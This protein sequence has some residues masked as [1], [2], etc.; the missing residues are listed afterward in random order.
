M[1]SRN[2]CGFGAGS[3]RVLGRASIA[4]GLLVALSTFAAAQTV[5]QNT[6]GRNPGTQVPPG[7]YIPDE[8]T[9]AEQTRLHSRT[10]IGAAGISAPSFKFGEYNGLNKFHAFAIGNFDYRGG[11]SYDSTDAWQWRF[12]GSSLGLET[13][14]GILDFGK[15]GK[16]QVRFAY[17]ELLANTSDSYQTPFL[18]VGSDTLSLPSTWV[19]PILPQKNATALNYFALNPVTAAGSVYNSKGVLTAPTQAQ[20]NAM[21]AIRAADLPAFRNVDLSL[22]RK[23]GETQLLFNPTASIDIPVSYSREHKNGLRTIGGVNDQNTQDSALLPYR[24]NW[25]TDQTSAAVNVKLHKLFL[26][27]AYYGS[28]FHNNTEHMLW[29]DPAVIGLTSA[30]AEEPSSQ[31]HQFTATGSYKLSRDAKLVV[32]GSIGRGTQNQAFINPSLSNEG[33]LPFGLPRPSLQGL[34]YTGL[35]AGKFTLKHGKWEL[36]A[37]ARFDERDNQTPLGIFLFQ[38]DASPKT[39]KSPFSGLY[40]LP[41]GLGTN[42]NIY[43]NRSLSK[44]SYKAGGEAEYSFSKSEHL[45]LGYGWD[46]ADRHCSYSWITCA[47][48]KETNENTFRTEWRKSKGALTARVEYAFSE[49]RGDYNENAFLAE[50]PMANQ[51]P[52]G[53]ASQSAYSYLKSTGLTGFGP[54]AGLPSAPLTGDAAIFTPNN[55]TLAQAQYGTRNILNEIPGFKRYYVADRNR[56]DAR[57][58]LLWL[59]KDKVAIEGSGE[60]SDDDYLNT[61]LGLK[62]RTWWAATMDVSYTASEDLVADVFYTYDNQRLYATGDAFGSNST[63]KFQGQAGDTVLGGPCFS[64]VAARN[65][66]AKIDPCLNWTHNDRDKIDT[67]GLTLRRKNL[68][69]GKLEL[70]GEAVYTRGRTENAVVGGSYVNNPLA[71][72]APAPKLPA[73]TQAIFFIPAQNYPVIRNDEVMV[74]PSA[75]Y[76]IS[77]AASLQGFYWFQRLSP[78]DW[79]YQGL[80]A[81]NKLNFTPTNETVPNYDVHVGGLAFNWAF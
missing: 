21:A 5:P 32:V 41:T 26:S 29:A 70:A 64:T 62:R 61:K 38:D 50:T 76:V 8:P 42:T 72:A 65:A 59:A 57:T 46:R 11:A 51:V 14:N 80:Q 47:D 60:L 19:V 31:F 39:G 77:K 12:R 13:R 35:G 18:G 67:A 28:F 48:A 52:A 2:A 6:T 49:R 45:M 66:S 34:V 73:G 37:D 23:R 20:L 44:L 27:F 74:K 53:G 56:N 1:K 40:G 68:A 10:Q 4:A 58:Q 63:A 30:L 78:T 36:V 54:V 43:N 81:G 17:N 7:I 9:A 33:A 75:T 69:G 22:T 79:R 71:L 15:Q 3:M 25:D 16:F 24:V 55:N